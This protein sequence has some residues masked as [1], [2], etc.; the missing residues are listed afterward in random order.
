LPLEHCWSYFAFIQTRLVEDKIALVVLL[1]HEVIAL[2]QNSS[3]GPFASSC[4][5][6]K[7]NGSLI[8]LFLS[9]LSTQG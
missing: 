7:F 2:P 4:H 1:P 5:S 6:I 9:S 8:R 3:S